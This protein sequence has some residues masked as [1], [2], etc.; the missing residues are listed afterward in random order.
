MP[1]AKRL[2]MRYPS[3]TVWNTVFISIVGVV[4]AI[5]LWVGYV[6]PFIEVLREPSGARYVASQRR[7]P[8]H[9]LGCEWADA[10]PT[11]EAVFY[12]HTWNAF[13]DG[14]RPCKFCN[15]KE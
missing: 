5:C 12:K 10:I 13:E 9:S 8:F 11:D 7:E 2:H 15:P 1:K 3:E 14:H 4:L 6:V